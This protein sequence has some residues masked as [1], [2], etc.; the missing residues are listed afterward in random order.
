MR[1][2]LICI[3]RQVNVWLRLGRPS[4]EIV[5]DRA[6]GTGSIEIDIDATT[7]STGNRALDAQLK[8]EDFFNVE[9]YPALTFR[10]TQVELEK[11]ELRAGPT[12]RPA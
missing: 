3:E 8:G 4:R 7:V 5:L 6:A 2:S 1:V 12:S 9:K 11:G 10:A